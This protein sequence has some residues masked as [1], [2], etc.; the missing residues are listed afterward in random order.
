MF[1]FWILAGLT[2]PY[3][4]T[5]LDGGEETRTFYDNFR[6]YK[7]NGEDNYDHEAWC[8]DKTWNGTL[9]E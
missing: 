5:Y 9:C 6:Y 4:S 7:W 3:P 2:G 1:N 8:G